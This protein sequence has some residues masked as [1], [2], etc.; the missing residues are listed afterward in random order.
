M[1]LRMDYSQ[2]DPAETVFPGN[3]PVVGTMNYPIQKEIL[4]MKRLSYH[5]PVQ[6]PLFMENRLSYPQ[7]KRFS[8]PSQSKTPANRKTIP[9]SSC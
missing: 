5:A 9:T 8:Y 6:L 3:F 7:E 4:D 1:T 2:K